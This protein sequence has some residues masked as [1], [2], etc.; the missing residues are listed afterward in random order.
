MRPALAAPYADAPGDGRRPDT[1]ATLTMDPPSSWTVIT[2]WADWAHHSGASRLRPTTASTKRG[3]ASAAMARGEPPA[4]FTRT[5]T[6]PKCST[7]VATT[8]SASAGLRTS[9]VTNTAP[10]TSASCRPHATT[11]APA[12]ANADTIPAPT[13]REPPVTTTTRSLKSKA[14]CVTG[15]TLRHGPDGRRWPRRARWPNVPAAF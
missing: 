15:Q 7:A 8:R 6:R 4:L 14:G 9:A 5:S 2:L 13:P 10:S 12:A 11:R 1:L 3:E